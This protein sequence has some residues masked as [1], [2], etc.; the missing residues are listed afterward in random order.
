MI[1]VG[2]TGAMGSGK[3]TIASFFKMRDIPV[4]SSDEAVHKIYEGSVS[5]RIEENFPGVTL[6]GRVDRSKLS[7]YLVEQPDRLE[8][9]EKIIHPLVAVEREAFIVQA[10]GSGARLVIIEVPLLFEKNLEQEFD[11]IVVAD[12]DE[13]LQNQRILSRKD[14]TESKYRTLMKRQIPQ[15]E[16]KR[17]AH[18]IFNT[19]R[20]K[21]I[22][23]RQIG[24]FLRAIASLISV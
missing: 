2:L 24:S 13:A 4:H 6:N 3:S 7:D 9:L 16:R 10:A 5:A 8:I 1:V 22:T 11:L 21:D 20:E 18:F 14:M 12:V 23:K 17:R 15:S 19:C